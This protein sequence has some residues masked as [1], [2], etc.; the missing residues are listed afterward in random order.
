MTSSLWATP[1]WVLTTL[2]TLSLLSFVPSFWSSFLNDK[3]PYGR[4][5]M[6][7]RMDLDVI[8]NALNLHDAQRKPIQGTSLEP[9]LGRYLQEL[10]KDYWGNPYLVDCNVGMVCS[11]GADC[12]AGG[13]DD[14]SDGLIYYKPPLKLCHVQY[15]GKFGPPQK[16]NK[17][18]ITMTKPYILKDGKEF[19]ASLNLLTDTGRS[20]S[21][22]PISFEELSYCRGHDWRLSKKESEPNNGVIVLVNHADYNEY[23][24]P[25][26]PGMALNFDTTEN[27]MGPDPLERF[28]L[29]EAP[30]AGGP[31]D[32]KIYGPQVVKY[33]RR[34]D[35]TEAY[36][37]G[38]SV[39]WNRGV[40]IEHFSV[41]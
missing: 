12:Q 5:G 25:I 34:P 39:S 7:S 35:F 2:L 29:R 36:S 30:L 20:P 28:G 1:C 17:F 37:F 27:A 14:D 23:A 13:T 11:Y 18:I 16:G 31:L 41:E 9:L 3:F 15:R 40:R 4:P 22:A 38:D 8:R 10:P 6:V 19:M 21:G 33:L 26:K 24:P 32:E